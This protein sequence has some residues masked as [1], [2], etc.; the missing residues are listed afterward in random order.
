VHHQELDDGQPVESI[1]EGWGRAGTN[2]SES[3]IK[4]RKIMIHEV[5]GDIL[6]SKAQ[7][8]AHGIAPNEHFEHG[9][10]LMLREKWPQMAKDYRHY[11]NQTHPKSGEIWAWGGF[12]TRI[13]NLLTHEGTFDHGGK[14]GKATLANV[15]HCLKRFRHWLEVEKVNS[16]AIPKLGTGVGGLHWE[17]VKPIV[18][19]YLSDL[20]IP[21]FVYTTYHPNQQGVE[22]GVS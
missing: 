15:R 21:V 9:L 1:D 17:D 7:V 18:Q 12:G 6:L 11:A 22:K 5:S 3:T 2:R 14:P 8:I 20:S 13:V 10:A 19:E 4:G 16:L